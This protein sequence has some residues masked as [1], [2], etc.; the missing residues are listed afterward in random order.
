MKKVIISIV[1]IIC[2]LFIY[3][4]DVLA[5]WAYL[6][7]SELEERADHVFVGRFNG[8]MSEDGKVRH[9]VR[10]WVVEIEHTLKG[11]DQEVIEIVTPGS[12][13]TVISVS[14]D[15]KLT[16]V[17]DGHML[18]Y[19]NKTNDG[20]YSP[21][22]PQGIINLEATEGGRILNAYNV[23]G[24]DDYESLEIEKSINRMVTED[25]NYILKWN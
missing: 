22:T 9:G 4:G 14:T 15:Y 1:I 21:I 8:E 25:N 13:L 20:K 10:Y 2:L 11:S 19:L 18:L 7:I 5:C 17:A 6:T 3:K 16:D 23:V 12:S 24:C